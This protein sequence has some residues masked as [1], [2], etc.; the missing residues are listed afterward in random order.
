M[1]NNFLKTVTACL[2]SIAVLV[3]ITS[4][5]KDFFEKKLYGSYA[6]CYSF[7]KIIFHKLSFLFFYD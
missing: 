5:K 2:G 4:C 7:K 1:K 6:S 3:C